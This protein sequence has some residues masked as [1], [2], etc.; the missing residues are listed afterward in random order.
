MVQAAYCI[1]RKE[2]V[3]IKRI[4]LEKC[5]TSMD[6]LLVRHT[7]VL[8]EQTH[9]RLSIFLTL[10]LLLF[11]QR[12]LL[13]HRTRFHLGLL[14]LWS[15]PVDRVSSTSA[16]HYWFSPSPPPIIPVTSN[17]ILVVLRK[18]D[19]AYCQETIRPPWDNLPEGYIVSLYPQCNLA[20]QPG[21]LF[22][23]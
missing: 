16:F 14:S 10:L 23:V 17:T 12:G 5:Q 18:E 1:P 3:A 20:P 15:V 13:P 4:N 21:T 9:I 7:T 6:E 22:T 2:K 19:S 8:H 11:D